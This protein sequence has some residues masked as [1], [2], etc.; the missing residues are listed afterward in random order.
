MR[1]STIDSVP[2][3]DM[4]KTYCRCGNIVSLDTR[5]VR[6]KHSLK[7]NV[8]CPICRNFR[9]SGELEYMNCLF[10]GTLDEQVGA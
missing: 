10:D 6:L 9:I 1:F 5:T 3:G 4:S 7:K 2:N 8:E